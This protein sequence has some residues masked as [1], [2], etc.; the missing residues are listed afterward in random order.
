VRARLLQTHGAGPGGGD[1]RGLRSAWR[2]S[3]GRLAGH[4]IEAGAPA[5]EPPENPRWFTPAS[6]RQSALRKSHPHPTDY[7][8][9]IL[10][11]VPSKSNRQIWLC[12]TSTLG[13]DQRRRC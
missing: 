13:P 11:L 10:P 2:R 5:C 7:A 4:G 3:L 9:S 6:S 12:A 1:G 8:I